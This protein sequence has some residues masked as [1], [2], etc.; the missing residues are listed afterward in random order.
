MFLQQLKIFFLKGLLA[1]VLALILD[2][3]NHLGD[4]RR[5]HRE[6]TL[7]ILPLKP[8]HLGEFFMNPF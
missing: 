4:L 8:A 1:V 5:A 3:I 7:A 2:V 6:S